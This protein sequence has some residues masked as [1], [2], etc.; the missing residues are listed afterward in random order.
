MTRARR[1]SRADRSR[2]TVHP[3]LKLSPGLVTAL[4]G[5]A[6]MSLLVCALGF[7]SAQ[8]HTATNM[9]TEEP[10][11]PLPAEPWLDE[12]RVAL[13]ERLFHDRRLSGSGTLSCSSCHDLASNGASGAARDRGDDGDLLAVNTPTVFNVATN[14]R[15]GWEGRFRHLPDHAAALIENPHIMGASLS[16]VVDRLR[17][18]RELAASFRNAYG[19]TIDEANLIDALVAFERSLVTPNAPFDRWL[20][21]DADALSALEVE[22]YQLFKATG[23]ASCHQG[24]GAGGNLFQKQGI[25]Q[26]LVRSP[27]HTVRVP[28]LRNVAATAPYFHDGSAATLGEAVGRMARTQLNASLSDVEIAKLVAFLGTLTGEYRGTALRPAP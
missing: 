4:C 10:I 27:P 2:P 24:V 28:S 7:A 26:P 17:S 6:A 3:S 16:E 8:P 15:L 20:K 1:R 19:R 25:F 14:F 5:A 21:G 23:C 9:A 22:G 12:A 11:S 13:G 18:D